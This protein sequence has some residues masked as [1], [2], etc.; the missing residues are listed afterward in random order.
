[1]NEEP[2]PNEQIDNLLSSIESAHELG[3]MNEHRF[4]VVLPS[5]IKSENPGE[6]RNLLVNVSDFTVLPNGTLIMYE[7]YSCPDHADGAVIHQR[8]SHVFAAKEWIS[9]LRVPEYE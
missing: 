3:Q 4:S 2:E 6:I 9:L 8:V 7:A 5:L 1:M